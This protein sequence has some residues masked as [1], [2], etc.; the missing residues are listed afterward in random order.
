MAA[1]NTS[2]ALLMDFRDLERRAAEIL[3]R[4]GDIDP[5]A[6]VRDALDLAA[7]AGRDRQGPDAGLPGADPRRADRRAD[8]AR[9]ADPLRDHAQAR[10]V[11]ASRSSTSR[12]AWPRSSTIA[13]ASP[14]CATASYITTMNVAET[15]PGEVV[16]AMVGRVIDSLY[17]DKLR[18]DE[19]SDEIILEVRGLTERRRFRDISFQLRKGEILGLAGLIGAGRSEIVKGICRLEGDVTGDVSPARPPAAASALCATASPRASSICP[20]TARATA[21]FSTCRS[22][23]MF[24]RSR[25]EQVAIADRHHRRRPGDRQAERLGGRLNLKATAMSA[26]RFLTCRAAISRR[27]PS[28][29]CSRSSR[30]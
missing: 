24:R 29:R 10:R 13:T 17:P 2:R 3:R 9:G 5:A 8:R 15:T 27:S 30:R 1:T 26:S 19:R 23:P 20:R 21:S 11:R 4:L 16:G 28:P 7:A 6:P 22:P 18:D 14:C 12:T 25:V